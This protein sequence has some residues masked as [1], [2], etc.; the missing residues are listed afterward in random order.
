MQHNSLLA[1]AT[2]RESITFSALLRL[3]SNTSRVEIDQRVNDVLKGL[4]IDNCADTL[5]GGGMIKGISGGEMK[6]TSVAIEIITEPN[7]RQC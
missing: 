2:P 5:I 1:T 6:R 7:V 3:P 4:G